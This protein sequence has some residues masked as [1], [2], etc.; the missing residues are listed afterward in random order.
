MQ[1]IAISRPLSKPE[2][3]KYQEIT[4]KNLRPLALSASHLFEKYGFKR[5]IYL[6]GAIQIQRIEK[7]LF[8]RVF[9]IFLAK[10]QVLGE[11]VFDSIVSLFMANSQQKQHYMMCYGC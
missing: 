9:R 4:K 11:P 2:I 10:K 6:I 3:A 8:F 5:D 1:K 7:N